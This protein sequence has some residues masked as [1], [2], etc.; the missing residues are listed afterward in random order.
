RNVDRLTYLT[1]D[2]MEISKLETGELKSK[3]Q[4]VYLHKIIT[5]VVENLKYK[6]EKEGVAIVSDEH[7][8]NLL[9]KADPNQIKRALINLTENAIKYNKIGG[10]VTVGTKPYPRDEQRVLI[11]VEDTGIGMKQEYIDRVT[12]RFFRID[13]SRSRNKG[14]TG[15]GLAIVK[16]IVEAH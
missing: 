16:H 13:K 9:V 8:E 4:N 14:G 10:M 2:L 1:E 7:D 15:L 12:E 6:A 5:E 11:Y 3:I